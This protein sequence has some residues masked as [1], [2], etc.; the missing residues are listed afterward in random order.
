MVRFFEDVCGTF[1]DS[2]FLHYNLPRTKRVLTGAEYARIVPRVPNLVATKNTGGGMPMA[3]DLVRLAPELMHFM[4]EGNYAYGAM[5]GDVGL[6]AS[7]AELAPEMTRRLYQAGRARAT[8]ELFELHHRFHVMSTDL[9]GAVPPGPHMDGA[10]DKML[11]KLRHVARLPAAPAVAVHGLHRR[12]LPDLPAAPRGALPGV[13]AV[14]VGFGI[15][16][17]GYM[18]RTYAACLTRHVP[19]GELRAVWGGKRAPAVAA[20]F[21][22]ESTETYEA[23]LAHPGVDAVIITSPHTAHREQAEAAAA[24]GKHVYIEKP[25]AL[26]V[27]EC[28]AIIDACRAAGVQLTVN[29]VTR[30]RDAPMAMKQLVD[31]GRIGDIRMIE[32]HGTWT[33]FLLEDIVDEATGRVIIPRKDWAF[34]PAE[35]SQ[36]LD[37]GVH[38]TD[39]LRWLTGSECVR[40][41]AQYRTYGTPPPVDLS[42]MVQYTM[43]DGVM[44]SMLMTYE[45]PEPGLVPNDTTRV[46]GSTGIIEA[47]H[48]GEVRLGDGL[49]VGHRR[50]AGAVRLPGR[51]PRPE[52]AQGVRRAGRGL[53]RRDRG[54][55]RAGGHRPRRASA[56]SR[57]SRPRTAPP[58]P[59]R[60]WSCRSP[61]RRAGQPGGPNE[62]RRPYSSKPR[63]R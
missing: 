12:R 10:F 60:P 23:L 43:A 51:L 42:A 38:E 47:D 11:V 45:V 61:E 49:V 18:G 16:G 56:P 13:P 2:T 36:F 6:L 32:M 4:G 25:M 50:P 62:R 29:F 52:P 24:A 59:A 26:S 58:R 22:T 19:N 40:A 44:A 7:Y 5:T 17:A 39:A 27:A 8:A 55:P 63:R 31:D 34:D 14:S 3:Y 48:Y 53:R 33:S 37:W 28:D 46:I 21:G 30:F 35:G 15:V 41:Y 1:P 54:G 9:W 20:E 57:W